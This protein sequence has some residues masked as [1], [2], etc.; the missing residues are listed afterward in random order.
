MLAQSLL[1]EEALLLRTFELASYAR[2]RTSPNPMVGAVIVQNGRIV[3][4]GYH[5]R[6]GLPHAEIEALRAAGELAR[7]ATLYVNLEPCCHSGRTGPCTEAIIAAGIKRVVAAMADPNPLVAGR[8]FARLK[9][10]GVEV[11]S[12]ILEKEARRLNEAFIKYITIRKPFVTL[13]AAMSLDGK[14]ATVTGESKWITGEEA[15]EYVHRLRDASDAVIV[16]IGTILK[17]DPSLTTRLP[18]GGRDPMRLILDSRARI[19]LEAR[20]LNLK[21]EA[22]TAVA[23]TEMAPPE[24]V[25]A[26][27][28]A[29]AE[30][31]V[32]GP[33]PRVDLDCLLAELAQREVVSILVEG[34]GTVNAG[35]V[36]QR[37]VDK[38]VWFIAPL[39]VG[40][41]EAPGPVGGSGIRNLSKAIRLTDITF[42]EYGADLCVEGYPI[43]EG[44]G[45]GCLPV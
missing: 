4:E 24:R 41:R 23:V 30:V 21:S 22:P 16:G 10:A 45:D 11:T 6:A 13:K 38:V 32:C 37:L 20:V 2:G 33:G 27:K 36:L 9:E 42:K 19:P 40:G 28:R 15:R 8:G 7:G 25:A 35:F 12:G 18:E 14:I 5:R 43:Y 29:G 26:I 17:D 3:G 31:L 44:A 39:I 1:A 34:G